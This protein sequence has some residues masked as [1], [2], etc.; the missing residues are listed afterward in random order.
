LKINYRAFAGNEDRD[1]SPEVAALVTSCPAP[2]RKESAIFS[3]QAM[4]PGHSARE[5]P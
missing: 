1:T 5:K 3:T 2:A 4:N